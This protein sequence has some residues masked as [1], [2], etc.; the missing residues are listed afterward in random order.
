MDEEHD[1]SYK[2]DSMPRYHARDV[3][4]ERAAYH[5]CKVVLSSAT[6]SWDSY[7]RGIIAG[8]TRGDNKYQIIR[9]T[10]DSISYQGY[11]ILTLCRACYTC[12]TGEQ[13]S[14]RKAA[15]WA[16]NRFPKHRALIAQAEE[17][18]RPGDPADDPARQ[19]ERTRAFIGFACDWITQNG[20]F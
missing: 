19:F 3:I 2:Q 1:G 15:Q 6:P 12:L 9:A 5:H 7:A 8:L 16:K 10:L 14:K 4:L 17:W 11:A 13:I 18:T 20:V